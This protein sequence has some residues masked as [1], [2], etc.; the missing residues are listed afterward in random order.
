M[1]LNPFA[2]QGDSPVFEPPVTPAA[3]PARAPNGA[4]DPSLQLACVTLGALTSHAFR[5]N[6]RDYESFRQSM[7]QLA[8]RVEESPD[9]AALAETG[10]AITREIERYNSTTQHVVNGSIEEL[11]DII[12]LL[13]A[14]VDSSRLD[15]THSEAALRQIEAAL[16]KTNTDEELRAAKGDLTEKLRALAGRERERQQQ[17]SD[18]AG[19]LQERVLVLEHSLNRET[20]PAPAPASAPPPAAEPAIDPLTGLPNKEAAENAILDLQR[21]HRRGAYLAAFYIQRMSHLNAR[22][23]DKIA[24]ELLLL[25]TQR[26]IG[27]VLRPKDHL[28]RWR[29]PAFL[30]L[31][32]R[33]DPVQ[34]VQREVR[35]L[36][37]RRFQCELR[38]GALIVSVDVA[39][40]VFCPSGKNCGQI[41]E[42]L[43]SFYTRNST[44]GA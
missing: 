31:I 24:D 4:P 28:F 39:G 13:L 20:A 6:H 23:G 18:L 14:A 8:K 1:K 2:K 36:V 19:R 11:Q 27:G 25:C 21:R 42:E 38:G 15:S 44:R 12:R 37:E 35:K 9:P 29:G 3:A 33:I 17:A 10:E 22:Y 26:L 16:G 7:T 41:I 5:W 34:H 40:D 30:A 32:E 43:E